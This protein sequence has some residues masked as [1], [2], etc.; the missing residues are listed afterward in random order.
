M[1]EDYLGTILGISTLIIYFLVI[2]L[3]LFHSRRDM[4][5]LEYFLKKYKPFWI[6]SKLI[7][8][9]FRNIAPRITKEMECGKQLPFPPPA[10]KGRFSRKCNFSIPKKSIRPVYKMSQSNSDKNNPKPV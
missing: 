5:A 9:N 7:Q 8:E 6:F 3:A 4:V 10:L 2:L 1:F